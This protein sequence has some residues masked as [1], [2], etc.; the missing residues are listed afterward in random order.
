M[1][2]SHIIFDLDGTLID[3]ASSVL[4]TF[5]ATLLAHGIESKVDLGSSLIG[6]PLYETLMKLTGA[7][8]PKLLDALADTFKSLYDTS[9][10]KQSRVYP[11]VPELLSKINQRNIP[12]YIATNKRLIPTRLIL[13]H[14]GWSQQFKTTYTLDGLEKPHANKSEML[15]HIMRK[16]GCDPIHTA[17][18]GDK[19]EDGI[20]ADENNIFFFYAC[21]GYGS[22]KKEE[23][24]AHWHIV[25]EPINL[26]SKLMRCTGVRLKR[27]SQPPRK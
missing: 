24:R 3:S 10:Y 9:G 5:E 11:G 21:W 4:A 14:F 8:D 23:I 18:I 19:F 7:E 25:P 17:Y 15:S 1:T 6:P 12:T 27:V 16:I 13:K 22:W 2:I 26:F 20:A